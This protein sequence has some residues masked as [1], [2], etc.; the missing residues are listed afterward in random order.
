MDRPVARWT[1][2]ESRA[3]AIE[4]GNAKPAAEGVGGRGLTLMLLVFSNRYLVYM[5]VWG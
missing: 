1:N 2:W 4:R 3:E 5:C